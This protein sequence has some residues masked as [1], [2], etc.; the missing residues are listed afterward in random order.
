LDYFNH[1]LERNI[2]L[3]VTLKTADQLEKELNA[4]TTAIHEAAW[5]CTPVIKES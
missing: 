3:R 1:L 2:N 4:F 5:N